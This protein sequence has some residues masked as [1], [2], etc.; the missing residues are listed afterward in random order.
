MSNIKQNIRSWFKPETR[1]QF[2]AAS[3]GIVTMLASLGFLS[4]SLV[5]AV[6]GVVLAALALAYA[7]VNSDS[8]KNKAIYALAAAIGA[9]LISLG[10]A[11]DN[12]AQSVLAVV[13]PV[14]G[15]SY[16]AAKTPDHNPGNDS[17]TVGAGPDPRVDGWVPTE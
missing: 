10:Y 13:A 8:T 5:P 17:V 2:Y 15:I 12:Q 4:V 11:T 6:T 3:A 1:G 14:L 9:L 7:Y 16:A